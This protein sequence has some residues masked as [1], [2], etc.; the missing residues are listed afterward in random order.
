MFLATTMLGLAEPASADTTVP[1]SSLTAGDTVNFGGYTWIVLDQ[2]GHLL[3]QVLFVSPQPFDSSGA[4]TFDP[5]SPTNIAYYLNNP[6]AAGGF[7]SSL[8]P[9]DQALV[10]PRKWTTGNETNESSSS[11]TCKIGLLSYSGYKTYQNVAGVN[12]GGSWWTR[13]PFSGMS[14]GVWLVAGDQLTNHAAR[15]VEQAPSLVAGPQNPVSLHIFHFRETYQ[16][17]MTNY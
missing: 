1:L 3:L 4:N 16:H 6:N 12:L 8:S 7:Y 2:T 14:E 9:T 5:T 11:V 15:A 17:D 10:Q 13:T